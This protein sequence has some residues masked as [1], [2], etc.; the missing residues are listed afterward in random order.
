MWVVSVFLLVAFQN[1]HLVSAECT[2]YLA[3]PCNLVQYGAMTR[4]KYHRWVLARTTPS[5][6]D[7][8]AR[9]IHEN[10][11]CIILS[12]IAELWGYILATK[13]RGLGGWGGCLLKTYWMVYNIW[14]FPFKEDICYWPINIIT[15]LGYVS[16]ITKQ[17]KI[18]KRLGRNK[19]KTPTPGDTLLFHTKDNRSLSS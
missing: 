12:G 4:A 15:E 18:K 17:R 7:H 10:M 3:V 19:K 8:L 9:N 14:T 6:Y 11:E 2:L 1:Y 13:M 5:S 16:L